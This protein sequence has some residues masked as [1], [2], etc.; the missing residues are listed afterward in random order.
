MISNKH[1]ITLFLLL[2][3]SL[4][5]FAQVKIGND[6][7]T[8]HDS[9]LLELESATKVLVLTRVRNSEMLGI[10]PLNGALVYN[11]DTKCVHSFNGVLWQ[12]LC[13][14][15][16]NVISII[17]NEDGSFTLL[18]TDGST[19]TSPDAASLK[20]EV[21]ATGATGAAGTNGLSAFQIA[22]NNGFSGTEAQWLTSLEGADGSNGDD[23]AAG[24]N[25]LSAYQ[26]AT[27]NGFSG[28][29][30]EWLTSLEGE[31]GNDGATGTAGSN[32]QSAYEIA[33]N[34]GFAGTETEWLASLQGADGNDGDTGAAGSNGQSAYEIAQSNGFAGTEAEWLESLEGA[35]GNDGD[36]GAA[37]SN[38]QS[39]YQI[40][41]SNGFAGTEAEWLASLQGADG[42]DGDTGVAGSNGQSAYQIAQNNGFAG[43]EAEWLE[44]LEGADGND[45]DTGAAGSNGQSAYEIAQN[46]GFAGTE[47]EWLASLQGA[48]GATAIKQNLDSPDT[49][50]TLSTSALTS[51][52]KTEI[53]TQGSAFSTSD[54]T[55]ASAVDLSIVACPFTPVESNIVGAKYV[56]EIQWEILETLGLFKNRFAIYVNNTRVTPVLNIWPNV[57]NITSAP[58]SRFFEYTSTGSDVIELR[59]S[60]AVGATGVSHVLNAQLKLRRSF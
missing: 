35:D 51:Y 9:S 41:Q 56:G 24:S 30:A 4:S 17:D 37:G 8:I 13:D 16:S 54:L 12:N 27:N 6:V 52:L 21:G 59:M 48:D 46:N 26:V 45:G 2:I 60:R 28:T 38:G 22:T 47:T 57:V 19:F 58:T 25:G 34:N 40:A 14:S 33:Q 15:T 3:T 44:S 49:I 31:D 55:G 53:L 43:T 1:Y 18:S 7:S 20:G 39:A 11:T 23:G 29:E 10:T 50:T 32:G 42:N 5:S 36:T